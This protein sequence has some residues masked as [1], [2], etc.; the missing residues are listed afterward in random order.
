MPNARFDFPDFVGKFPPVPMPITLGEDSHHV[1]SIENQPLPIEMIEQFI[2]PANPD[3]TPPDDEYT[4]YVPCLAIDDTD[5]F[6]ALIWWKASLLHY[7]YVLA[8]FNLKGEQIDRRVI[9]HTRIQNGRISRAVA[10][11]DEDWVVFIAEGE[12]ADGDIF[13]PTSSRTYEV[14]IMNDGTIA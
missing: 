7:E 10:T 9:G 8:T 5:G 11:I 3:G 1:F 2:Q 14:E 13:D 6:V 4:E 12:S